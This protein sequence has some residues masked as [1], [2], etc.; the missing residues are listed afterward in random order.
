[1]YTNLKPNYKINEL[2][3]FNPY[4]HE[5]VSDRL[6]VLLWENLSLYNLLEPKQILGEKS[7]QELMNQKP[8][9]S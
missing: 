3:N 8:T 4:R 6:M 5:Y 9:F 2:D 1:M 7:P